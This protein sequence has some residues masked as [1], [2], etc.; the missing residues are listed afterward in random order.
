MQTQCLQ[1]SLCN[2]LVLKNNTHIKFFLKVFLYNEEN[3]KIW[4]AHRINR[5]Q[6]EKKVSCLL[7]SKPKTVII[8]QINSINS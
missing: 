1:L 3:F 6:G 5:N 4:I 7:Y 8:S 2:D